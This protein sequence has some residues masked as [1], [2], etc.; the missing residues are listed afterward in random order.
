M[1][2]RQPIPGAIPAAS[3]QVSK[4]STARTLAPELF[5]AA[6]LTVRL[7]RCTAR[8]LPRLADAALR[9]VHVEGW[10]S[11]RYSNANDFARERLD[12]SG[13]WLRQLARLGQACRELPALADAISGA[14]GGKPLGRAA[15]YEICR[16][17]RPE[18]L[19]GWINQAR[20]CTIR[21]LKRAVRREMDNRPSSVANLAQQH[22]RASLGMH[23]PVVLDRALTGIERA[24]LASNPSS[25]RHDLI[26]AL[27]AEHASGNGAGMLELGD[28]AA[29]TGRSGPLMRSPSR[30]G[31]SHSPDADA[32]LDDGLA[33][34]RVVENTT[35]RELLKAR[36]SLH[37][38]DLFIAALDE[39]TRKVTAPARHNVASAAC[40]DSDHRMP[41]T[42]PDDTSSAENLAQSMSDVLALDHE[43]K[44]R[45]DRLLLWLE[46]RRAWSLLGYADAGEFGQRM[47]D[48][49]ASTTRNRLRL[50][51][52]LERS[53]ALLRGAESGRVSHQRLVRLAHLMQQHRSHGLHKTNLQE[54]K[55]I[56]QWVDHSARVSIKRLDEDLDVVEHRRRAARDVRVEHAGVPLPPTDAEWQA[57]LQ[58]VPGEARRCLLLGGLQ[59]LASEAPANVWRRFSGPAATIR[60]LRHS[61]NL[62]RVRL[63]Q[64]A[65][66]LTAVSPSPADESRLFPSIRLAARHLES[67]RPIADWIC[68]LSL[69][70]EW[71][72]EWDNPRHMPRRSTDAIASRDG[73]R[74]TAPGCTSR[75][76]E[77]HHIVYRSHGGTDDPTNLTSL[78]PFHHR[79]GEHAGLLKVTGTAPLGLRW[80]MGNRVYVNERLVE[81]H[82]A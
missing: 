42:T 31:L 65:R 26:D 23:L 77:V 14:D 30:P 7:R 37:R 17:A 58:L 25:R 33:S 80:Q 13:S 69:L 8:L 78:C 34:E 59:L 1:I 68:L 73:W 49:S 11:L 28:P 66:D 27:N 45:I 64:Q 67:G 9:L 35:N 82:R 52:A 55:T 15:A 79:M 57:S 38:V 32:M 5:I 40:S 60:D 16:V 2:Q 70:E 76:I 62:V 22:P 6:Q 43:I 39:V 24:F 53:P 4:T 20:T 10:K 21:D 19:T 46:Q 74:C 29:R 12:R 44:L 47:L 51:R 50:A 81:E 72:E 36:W 54:E 71:A 48:E 41:D 75:E 3:A 56:Q 18:T 63:A 61:L